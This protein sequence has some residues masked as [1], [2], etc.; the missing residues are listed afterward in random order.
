MPSN[1]NTKSSDKQAFH[2]NLEIFWQD[3]VRRYQ[4]Y[5]EDRKQLRLR[6]TGLIFAILSLEVATLSSMEKFNKSEPSLI[7]AG[8]II[9]GTA[10]QVSCYF[11]IEKPVS[12]EGGDFEISGLEDKLVRDEEITDEDIR[13]ITRGMLS[14]GDAY[15]EDSTAKHPKYTYMLRISLILIPCIVIFFLINK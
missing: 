14:A 15:R 2:T 12:V 10:I 9:S 1:K 5:V 4:E 13:S 11:E 7:L 8:L 6:A 3:S